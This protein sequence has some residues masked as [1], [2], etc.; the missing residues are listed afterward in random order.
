VSASLSRA[1]QE[2]DDLP[3]IGGKPVLPTCEI[4][5]P[6]MAL[7]QNRNFPTCEILY[8]KMALMQNRNFRS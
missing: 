4:F 1:K 2:V 5:Y 8:A 7:M 6:K 3:K